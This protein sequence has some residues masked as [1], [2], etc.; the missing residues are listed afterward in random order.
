MDKPCPDCGC[1]VPHRCW[2]EK[3][4]FVTEDSSV[5]PR[6]GTERSS[7]KEGVVAKKRRKTGC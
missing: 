1:L 4:R 7:G 2:R 5:S 3:S 6:G